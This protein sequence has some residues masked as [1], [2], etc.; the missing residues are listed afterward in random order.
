[1][2][3]ARPYGYV[4]TPLDDAIVLKIQPF[5]P[6]QIKSFINQW[7]LIDESM[8]SQK[9]DP[10]VQ[11]RASEGA[12]NLLAALQQKRSLWELAANPLLLTMI[13]TLASTGGSLPNDRLQ[14]YRE[15]FQVLLYRR[16]DAIGLTPKLPVQQKL[17]LLQ[18]LA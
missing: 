14:L 4:D 17:E 12:G 6:T 2:I 1:M 10:G 11:L 13:A 7:F 9:R 15:I 16:R 5:S 8:R 3:T 18:P